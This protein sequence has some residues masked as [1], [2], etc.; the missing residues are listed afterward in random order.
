MLKFKDWIILSKEEKA[1]KY[2]DL[3]DD[4]KFLVRQGDYFNLDDEADTK[5]DSEFIKEINKMYEEI[6]STQ[7]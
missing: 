7:K 5:Y 6:E 4:D 1:K 3:S 2:A